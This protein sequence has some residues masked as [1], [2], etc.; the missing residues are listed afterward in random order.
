MRSAK[1]VRKIIAVVATG[2]AAICVGT[3]VGVTDSANCRNVGDICPDGTINAGL[4][5]DGERSIYTTPNDLPWAVTWNDG[6]RD[7][8]V[9]TGLASVT[10]GET[11]TARLAAIAISGYSFNAA[12]YC[13]NLESHGHKDWYL[14]A[15]DE[16]AIL[17]NNKAAIGG[18]FTD[19]N[20]EYWSSTEY[21][22]IFAWAH[23][24]STGFQNGAVKDN[25]LR[26]RCIRR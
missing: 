19:A 9:V 17:F 6:S 21:S 11:N 24:F 7:W 12:E 2:F 18:F 10:N 1:R 8:T 26:V 13:E 3:T 5:P 23:N 14:P 25:F 15:R 20:A 22:N 4:S 16:L